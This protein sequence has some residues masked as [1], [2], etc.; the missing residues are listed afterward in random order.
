VGTAIVAMTDHSRAYDYPSVVHLQVNDDSIENYV[1]AADF[2]N[3]GHFDVVS[4]QHE[5][6]I[7]GGEA[8]AHIMALLMRLNMPIVTTL[9]SVL[10][11][12]TP[13]QRRVLD[14]IAEASSRVVVMAEKG[15]ELLRS[16]YRVPAEK[17]EVI[18]RGIPDFP[19]VEPDKAAGQSEGHL[20]KYPLMV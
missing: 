6:G 8:G 7:F 14:R 10:S 19:F 11:E 20:E 9:H 12:P 17:I 13:A 3:A 16:V 1:H 18:P 2:L 5:F 4:L 15:R